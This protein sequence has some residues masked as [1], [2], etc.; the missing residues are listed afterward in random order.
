[1]LSKLEA[2]LSHHYPLINSTLQNKLQLCESLGFGSGVV[3][4][5]VQT[6]CGSD[7]LG[8]WWPMFRDNVEVS[9]SGVE[10]PMNI[11][12]WTFKP[13]KMRPP[14]CLKTL[15]TNYPAT[16]CNIPE[17]RWPHIMPSLCLGASL[18]FLF[19]LIWKLLI[20]TSVTDMS[21]CI[22]CAMEK[23]SP[24]NF[25]VYAIRFSLIGTTVF[26]NFGIP[27]QHGP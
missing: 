20:L 18:S 10:M 22:V 13:F 16:E 7:L 14:A 12:M 9:S 1:V 25:V 4:V 2:W 23:N 6:G 8:D 17:Q 24:H 5:S 3:E 26:Q 15:G 19:N 21:I 11:S 27:N